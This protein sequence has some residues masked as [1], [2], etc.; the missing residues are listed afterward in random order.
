MTTTDLGLPFIEGSQAQKHVTHNEAL[1][2]LDAAIQSGCWIL[3]APRAPSPA[4]ASA[5]CAT[6]AMH[7]AGHSNAIAT[8]QDGIWAFL[9]PRTG[10]CIWSVRD[11]V[12]FVFDGSIG[13]LARSAGDAGPTRACGH[14]HV[15]EFAQSVE[16]EIQRVLLTAIAVATAATAT[17]GCRFQRKVPPNRVGFSPT[18]FRT[19]GIRACRSDAFS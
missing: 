15:S 3:C 1:R 10:W 4:R 7:M 16:R 14:Q 9:A 12:V 18:I 13:R 17:C 11:N 2:I 8:W 5:T 6:G 19:R